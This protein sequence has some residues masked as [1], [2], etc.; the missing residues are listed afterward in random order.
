[1]S[2]IPKHGDFKIDRI[3]VQA[4]GRAYETYEVSGYLAGRRVRWRSRSQDKALGEK[5][6]LEV[7]AANSA[8]DIQAVNTRLSRDQVAEAEIAFRRLGGKQLSEAVDWYLS[9]YKSAVTEIGLT[10]ATEAFLAEKVLHVRTPCLLDYRHSLAAFCARF[11]DRN[12]QTI[13][14][15][16]VQEFLNLRP[17]GKKRFNNLR[18]DLHAFFHFCQKRPREW[19]RDNPVNPIPK[20]K[21]SHGVPE[22]IS[23]Q[24]AAD[25]MAFVENYSRDPMNDL[26]RGFLVPYFALCLFAGLRPSVRDGEISKLAEMSDLPKFIKM[27]LGVIQL[28]P[29][30]AKTK[31]SRKVTILPNLAAW[32]AQYPPSKYPIIVPNMSQHTATVRKKFGLGHDVLRHTYISMHVAKFKSLCEAALEAGN[33]EVMIRRHYLNMVSDSDAEKFWSIIPQLR[34]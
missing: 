20:F 28:T 27:D 6:R 24:T 23:A 19:M 29:E 4:R 9:T 17:Y 15:G 33:S 3:K 7:R 25:L 30:M 34:N 11:P 12:V 8:G 31:H 22:I 18:G 13:T 2:G 5:A 32:L 26:D 1:M 10:Y 16:E 21:I 14:T